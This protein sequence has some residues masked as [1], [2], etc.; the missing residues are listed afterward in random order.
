MACTPL[1]AAPFTRLSRA[2]ITTSRDPR[3][4]FSN[5][6]SQKFVP[7]RIFGSGYR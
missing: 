5:P 6:M 1:P 7:A 2:D 3:G 4:S